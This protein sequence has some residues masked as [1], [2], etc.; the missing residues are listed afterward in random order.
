MLPHE[1]CR[2]IGKMLDY[3]SRIN[4]NCVM[5]PYDRFTK[6]IESDAHN[7]YVVCTEYARLLKE[8][9][10]NWDCQ[11]K[12]CIA[13]V[14]MM[15]YLLDSKDDALFTNPNFKNMTL[16]KTIEFPAQLQGNET[17]IS[18]EN[19]TQIRDVCVKLR[20]KITQ[21]EPDLPKR[22]IQLVSIM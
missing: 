14:K 5:E 11:N 2:E 20:D 6:R 18:V 15:K 1:I 3:E 4:Y 21:M 9:Y 8:I 10:D 7:A 12:R 17:V 16:E 22:K 13:T 19:Q